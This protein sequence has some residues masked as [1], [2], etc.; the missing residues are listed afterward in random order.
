M[1]VSGCNEG[2]TDVYQVMSVFYILPFRCTLLAEV[3]DGQHHSSTEVAQTIS[4]LLY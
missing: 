4:Q 3:R 1:P 2:V